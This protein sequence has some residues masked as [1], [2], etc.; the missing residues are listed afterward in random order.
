MAK[1]RKEQAPKV[2]DTY[3]PADETA[4]LLGQD[5]LKM[6]SYSEQKRFL[7]LARSIPDDITSRM[8]QEN[9][10]YGR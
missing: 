3:S 5:A 6:A 4:W 8:E 9:I 7:L 10:L 2:N 1:R